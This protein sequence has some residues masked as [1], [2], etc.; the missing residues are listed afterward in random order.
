MNKDSRQVDEFARIGLKAEAKGQPNP[1]PDATRAKRLHLSIGKKCELVEVFDALSCKLNPTDEEVKSHLE[2][3]NYAYESPQHV[4]DNVKKLKAKF[5]SKVSRATSIPVRLGIM[6]KDID[7]VCESLSAYF[8]PFIE[9]CRKNMEGIEFLKNLEMKFEDDESTEQSKANVLAHLKEELQCNGMHASF[10]KAYD[11]LRMQLF[12]MPKT[13]GEFLEWCYKSP[14]VAFER[15]MHCKKAFRTLD[16]AV[17][18]IIPHI[19][20]RAKYL[21]GTFIDISKEKVVSLNNSQVRDAMSSL[22]QGESSSGA[23]QIS[24]KIK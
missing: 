7:G 14:S 5:D 4:T 11:N 23:V 24:N 17:K 10:T 8:W 19:K 1:F 3:L 18:T 21:D 9:A 16:V 22:P 6:A 13:Q 15:I 12:R 20:Q 2:L